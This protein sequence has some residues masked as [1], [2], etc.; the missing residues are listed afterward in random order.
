MSELTGQRLLPAEHR[1]LRE[2][3]A[4][5]AHLRGHWARL[6]RRLGDQPVL[7]RGAAAAGE[8]LGELEDRTR[9]H[10]L[11]TFP[12]ALGAGRGGARLRGAG[13]LLLERNQALRTAVLDVQHAVTL[14]AYLAEL[15]AAR[16]DAALAAWH[17]SWEER[18]RGVESDARAVAAATGR[19]PAAAIEPAD[20]SPVGRAGHRIASGLG[21]LGESIDA[22][23]V[24]RAARRAR[25]G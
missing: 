19:D 4:A 18:L 24:G 1:A 3:H 10:G 21:A 14:L 8:L 11:Q 5:A 13:D 6:A 17:R 12:A 16:G 7:E 15:A 22:S 25:R 2:L 23:A 9:A 20:V